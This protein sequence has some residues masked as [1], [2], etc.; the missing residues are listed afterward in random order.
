MSK[1]KYGLLKRLTFWILFLGRDKYSKSR[2]ERL[3]KQQAFQKIPIDV[4]IILYCSIRKELRYKRRKVCPKKKK[5]FWCSFKNNQKINKPKN[6]N[7]SIRKKNCMS[8]SKYSTLKR[9]TYW[10]LVLGRD[11]CN[12]SRAEG[13]Q[14]ENAF[15]KILTHAKKIFYFA[16]S[17][18]LKNDIRYVPTK[19]YQK[20]IKD[21][22][23]N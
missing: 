5:D 17:S 14:K 4:K 13:L 12:K 2:S 23:A 11:K 9:L 8:Q 20:V 6:I 21:Y 18:C 15:H 16:W 10:F 22:Q 7:L 1:S 19:K 3:Q